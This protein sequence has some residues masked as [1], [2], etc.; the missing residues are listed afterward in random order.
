M[1]AQPARTDE[2]LRS[3][4][5]AKGGAGAVNT[6]S[7]DDFDRDVWCVLGLPIDMATVP[8]AV[9]KIEAAVRDRRRL[10]FVTPNVNWL[11]RALR[12]PKARREVLNADLSL[13]DG[14]PLAAMA[15]LL[16]APLNGRVAGSDI[17]E[18]LRLR[19]GFRPIRVFF[20]G[21]REGAGK[22]ACEALKKTP[23]GLEPAGWLNPGFGDVA[24]MSTDAVVDRINAADPDFV[25]V[26]LGAAKGQAWIEANQDRLR[27]PAI[28]HLGAVVDFTAG[29]IRRAPRWLGR[30]G[31][32]WAWRIAQEPSLWRRYYRDGLAL[33]RLA[34][35]RLAPQ[36]GLGRARPG[37]GR[38]RVVRRADAAVVRLEGDFVRGGLDEAR[39][40]FREAARAGA[41]VVLD[42]SAVKT[43]DRAFLGLVLMLEKHLPDGQLK[44][45]GAHARLRKLFH[46]NAM[47]YPAAHIGAD[48]A[49]A[50]RR[51]AG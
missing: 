9:M 22:G 49:R 2:S 10:S 47:H 17:F 35:F 42:L 50:A 18:A 19:P 51:A 23:G 20:L 37:V 32:E 28:A 14:A 5:S 34:A 30:A 31:L 16:G 3:A 33:L 13:A 45:T 1:T 40:A 48:E 6:L 26:A 27:A 44:M 21:G 8:G 25:V 4:T 36:I 46:A 11:V 41:A 29:A 43:A 7:G 39:A 15:R 12:D 38:A 24:S